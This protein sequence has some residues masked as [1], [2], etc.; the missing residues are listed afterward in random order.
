MQLRKQHKKKGKAKPILQ[1]R[2]AL[3]EGARGALQ[4]TAGFRHR[5][6]SGRNLLLCRRSSSRNISQ[7]EAIS[8]A[9]LQGHEQDSDLFPGNQAK[10]LF[11]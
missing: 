2:S 9:R 1:I 6:E 4:S 8:S 10:D 11:N 7:I 5:L 3:H